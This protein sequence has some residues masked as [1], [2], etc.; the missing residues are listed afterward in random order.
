M[1]TKCPKCHNH[2]VSFLD[3][4]FIIYRSP[5][6]SNCGSRLKR[7]YCYDFLPDIMIYLLFMFFGFKFFLF[8]DYFSIVALLSSYLLIELFKFYFIPLKS[9]SAE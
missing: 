5:I 6:C 3:R 8:R 1:K 9:V 7:I 2:T 4:V